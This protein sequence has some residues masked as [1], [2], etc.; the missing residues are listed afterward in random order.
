MMKKINS[1][2]I[3]LASKSKS[4]KKVLEN[5]GLKFETISSGVDEDEIKTRMSGTGATFEQ[6]A[7]ALACEK[8]LSVSKS[9]LESLIIGGDQILVCDGKHYDKAKNIEEARNHLKFFRGRTHE[10]VTSI[11]VVL[12]GRVIWKNTSRPLLSMWNFSDEFLEE[13]IGKAGDALLQSVGGYYIEGLGI[14][15]FSNIEGEY[16]AI[17]GMPMLALLN[18]LREIYE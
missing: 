5:A 16:H 11:A 8:A 9:H 13:Y 14:H 1:S 17:Q 3:I 18:K 2:K 15:L 4:R 6:I 10:L 12:N 7:E